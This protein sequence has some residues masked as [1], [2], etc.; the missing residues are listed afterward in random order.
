MP[1]FQVINSI[2]KEAVPEREFDDP[3]EAG[4]FAARMTD[5][6]NFK[7]V[8]KPIK[9]APTASV[10]TDAPWKQ[11]ERDRFVSGEYLP[12]VGKL[13]TLTND[14]YPDHFA[15]V[16]KNRPNAIA[17]TPDEEFGEADRQRRMTVA[18]Y[19]ERFFNNLTPQ[20]I[21]EIVEEHSNHFD[22]IELKWATT[23]PDIANVYMNFSSDW[24]S[25]AGSCMRYGYRGTPG[26]EEDG[27][28]PFY[29]KVHPT[30]AYASPDLALAYLTDKWGNT[31]ARALCWP[32]KRLY[33]RAYGDGNRLVTLLK[34]QGYRPSAGYYP[35][36]TYE[37]TNPEK[38]SFQGARLTKIKHGKHEW[39]MPYLDEIGRISHSKDKQYFIFDTAGMGAQST[40]GTIEAEEERPCAHCKEMTY[41]SAV[42]HVAS[43]I[44]SRGY[45]DR[46]DERC[47][48]CYEN[49]EESYYC[50]GLNIR[51]LRSACEP[52]EIDGLTYNSNYGRINRRTCEKT[53]VTVWNRHGANVIVEIGP[54]S[55]YS[56]REWWCYDAI[57]QHAFVTCSD[58]S[59]WD[60]GPLY[61][62]DLMQPRTLSREATALIGRDR[63]GSVH[64]HIGRLATNS[65]SNTEAA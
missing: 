31:T 27:A 43:V 32:E 54:S 62:R 5:V 3:K 58:Y 26:C 50:N 35:R 34:K 24:N 9:S 57:R 18:G 64:T 56:R 13:L 53:G 33:T 48:A 36:S 10:P 41:G 52:M 19:L 65:N 6:T 20:L 1:K 45:A 40:D 16:S 60:H 14:R 23:A 59:T 55:D 39:V 37:A 25:L 28:A 12:L 17:Y 42:N 63:Y 61:S 47:P 11:R 4:A 21:A 29:T 46:R 30:A 2:T 38:L 49:D 22:T 44:H 51:V 7:H 8:V 15:H